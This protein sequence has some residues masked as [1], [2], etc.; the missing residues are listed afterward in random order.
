M[1]IAL[2]EKAIAHPFDSKLLEIARIKQVEAA[3]AEGIELKQTFVK[4][5]QQLGLKAGCYNHVRQLKRKLKVYDSND[6][7]RSSRSSVT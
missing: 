2:Q 6:N 7:K 3:K 1:E 5:G 4:E